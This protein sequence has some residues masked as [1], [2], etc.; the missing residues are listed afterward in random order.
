MKSI[1]DDRIIFSSS[2]SSNTRQPSSGAVVSAAMRL[3]LDKRKV[4]CVSMIEPTMT[5]KIHRGVHRT[6]E[7]HIHKKRKVCFSDLS[8]LVLTEEKTTQDRCNA[9]YSRDDITKF[10]KNA[11]L[12]S[13]ALR[14]TR[15]AKVMKHIA[16]S[17]SHNAPLAT[18]DV[19]GK[20]V[21][22]G[23]E[24]LISSEVM[25]YIIDRRKSLIKRVLYEQ[26]IQRV[27]GINDPSA[28][29]YLSE[30]NS[31]FSKEWCSRITTF[32]YDA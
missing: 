27:E 20:E 2:S 13:C 5:M 4:S 22:R 31:S 16:S 19:K 26:K 28:L 25:K 17:A 30:V 23:I 29:A 15:T 10:K 12:T 6:A 14:K 9:W 7:Q 1:M 11:H 32:Q 18:V 21:I 24:H 8:S 3:D